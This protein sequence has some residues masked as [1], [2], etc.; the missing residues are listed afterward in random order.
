MPPVDLVA[1]LPG[2][3]IWG[4]VPGALVVQMLVPS[5]PI[6]YRIAMI[7]A[8]SAG[9]VGG[10]G[11]VLRL[12]HIR[13]SVVSVGLV[14]TALACTAIV[15]TR[16]R[17]RSG[18]R[19]PLVGRGPLILAA[20]ALAA[21]TCSALVMS[22]RMANAPLPIWNDPAF[23]G[24]V[25]H[26]IGV[27]GDVLPPIGVPAAGIDVYR[28]QMAF[29]ATASLVA[30]ISGTNP[31]HTLAPLCLLAVLVLPASLAALGVE[32]SGSARVGG[33]AAL[34]GV[35]MALPSFVVDFGDFPLVL[36]STLV[37]PAV[38][39]LR[40][41]VL[42]E[43]KRSLVL[44]G[45]IAAC[46]WLIHG[47]E[48]FTAAVIAVPA[49]AIPALLKTPRTSALRL[50]LAGGLVGAGA[51]ALALVTAHEVAPPLP[52]AVPTLGSRADFTDVVISFYRVTLADPVL[53]LAFAVG[54]IT[55]VVTGQLRGI[56]A[57]HMIIVAIL[58]DRDVT[59]VLGTLWL[60]TSVWSE[61]DRLITLQYFVVPPIAAVGLVTGWERT[62]TAEQVPA[63]ARRALTVVGAALVG[64]ILAMGMES[65]ASRYTAFIADHGVVTTA[66][67]TVLSRMDVHLP[68][69]T[70]V[71]TNDSA[72]AGKWID[73][74][75]QDHVLLTK[76]WTDSYPNDTR[77]VGL[78]NA[79]TDAAGA[80]RALRGISAIYVG[81]R[82]DSA[83]QH[84]WSLA[85]VAAVPGVHIVDSAAG[86]E[87]TA[88]LLTVDPQVSP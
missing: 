1:A 39:A 53:G 61:S 35:G 18:A 83:A 38:V 40:R 69:G 15:V 32:L 22:A 51:I 37:V 56:L 86:P 21:G 60:R 57:A 16:R 46:I 28:P 70:F 42:D 20:V 67:V 48:A 3:L 33:V 55:V 63:S 87:G 81:A 50:T 2:L 80:L 10:V 30:S 78:E 59:H 65:D 43:D 79:C 9:F 58:I 54:V 49:V 17:R 75:T 4:I 5:W 88:A 6:V 47:S 64:V 26:A 66:D 45:G 34:L 74:L 7:P 27:S 29:E 14:L 44:L 24:A 71:L 13:F 41:Y 23:H 19:P 84:R 62:R 12:V 77:I 11:V 72:D 25:A 52:G 82:E 85:C 8:L 68:P 36:D 76:A 73:T 31:A